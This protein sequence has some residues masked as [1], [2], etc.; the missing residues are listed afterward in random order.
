MSKI[1][2]FSL[3]IFTHCASAQR[4]LSPPSILVVTAHPDDELMFSATLYRITHALEGTVDI[5]VM[6]DGAGGYRFST[7]S[8]SIYRRELTD[9]DVA[10]EY[11]PAIRKRELMASGALA[12]VR[13]YFFHEQ[14]DLGVTENQDSILGFVW[15]REFVGERL[16]YILAKGDY[17]FVF[18]HLPIKP[19]HAHH[20]SATIL[21]IE[22]VHRMPPVE[23]PVILG[24]FTDRYYKETV[25]SYSQLEGHPLTKVF[26]VGPFIFDRATSFGFDDRLNYSIIY[27]WMV[28]EYKSQGFQQML[29]DDPAKPAVE[30]F[31]VFEMN[32]R[33]AI[34]R[35]EALLKQV[36]SAPF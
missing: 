19:F 29:M 11:L 28:G 36:R 1:L 3:L 30:Q 9:P 17:D 31:W 32:G 4:V 12:G 20:K 10:K 5:S 24:S 34:V 14:P 8:E 23:R 2:I 33:D 13:N 18:T 22:A 15:D 7:L 25:D 26:E 21:A 35:A 6:T 16:D 27:N